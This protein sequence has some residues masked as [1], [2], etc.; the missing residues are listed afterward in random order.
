MLGCVVDDPVSLLSGAD[1]PKRSFIH[2]PANCRAHV[3]FALT[4]CSS[5]GCLPLP[6]NLPFLADDANLQS[7]AISV[8]RLLLAKG[9][10]R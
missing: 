4:S 10:N 5:P 7:N 6:R 1:R 3:C 2:I 9:A 8:V